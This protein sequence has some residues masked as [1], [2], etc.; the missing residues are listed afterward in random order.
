MLSK[1]RPILFEVMGNRG[2][3]AGGRPARETPAPRARAKAAPRE[4]KNPFESPVVRWAALAGV[5]LVAIIFAVWRMQRPSPAQ[6]PQLQTNV[7][8]E[9]RMGADPAPSG[10]RAP[11]HVFTICAL[12][13]PYK[14]LAE[15]KLAREKV[16]EIVN[17]LGY[18]SDPVFRQDVRAKDFPSKESGAGAFRIY[19]GSADRKPELIPLR[20]KLAQVVY[21]KTYPFRN[22]SIRMVER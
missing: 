8:D 1:K 17:F 16:E 22:A 15:R 9:A 7:H 19:V 11:A 20:D 12:E 6:V 3:A 5:V 2:R 18:D 10:G 14:T 21:K 4:R 13:K